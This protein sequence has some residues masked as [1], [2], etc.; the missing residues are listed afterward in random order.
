M[1]V[2]AL[3]ALLAG[4]PPV[5]DK[6]G[7]TAPPPDP[8]SGRAT[9][10]GHAAWDP[11]VTWRSDGVVSAPVLV[12]PDGGSPAYTRLLSA[13]GLPLG[14]DD[15]PVWVPTDDLE[16][17]RYSVEP[18]TDVDAWNGEDSADILPYGLDP[19]FDPAA[20]VGVTYGLRSAA[21]LQPA[22]ADSFAQTYVPA[23]RLQILGVEGGQ[24]RFRLLFDDPDL[25]PACE[26]LRATGALSETGRLTWSLAEAE[27]ATTPEPTPLRH[28]S[29]ELGFLGDGSEAGGARA[30]VTAD[31]RNIRDD[32]G[33]VV[34]CDLLGSF[35]E[36]CWDCLG[37]G[38]ASCASFAVYAGVFAPVGATYADELP[39]CGLDT[40]AA[41]EAL[42]CEWDGD[43]C[44]LSTLV[45]FLTLAAAR[46]R[47]RATKA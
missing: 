25:A 33:E 8:V 13:E 46:R 37:D 19:S 20:V 26:V 17:V 44:A 12:A 41:G 31:V 7:D 39:S 35:R 34:V 11:V 38:E 22:D 16:A 3:V 23:V 45:P 36:T 21:L 28:L 29:L 30:T 43:I 1:R 40:E 47:K 42:S 5:G 6:P 2:G 27:A 32:D 10:L 14:G 24:A 18:P 15:A 4:C 9:L